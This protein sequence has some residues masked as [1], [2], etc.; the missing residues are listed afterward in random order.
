MTN[1]RKIALLS[2]SLF[3]LTSCSTLVTPV[4]RETLSSCYIVFDAGSSGTR[5][6]VYEKQGT[7]WL[8][9]AGPKVTALADPIRE[10]RG[11]KNTDIE[12]VTTEVVAALDNMTQDGPI[13]KKG[14]PAWIGF[15]W[16][17]QCQVV[18]SMV[19]ATAGMRL[20]EQEDREKSIALWTTLKQK[21]QAKV[22]DAVAV[23]TRT[24]TGYEEGLYAW[25]AVRTQ[26]QHNT[27]GIAEMGGA[28]SQVTFPCS[29]CDV[30]D[31]ALKLVLVNGSPLPIYSYSFLGLGQDEAPTTLGMPES[32]AYGIGTTQSDWNVNDCANQIPITDTQGIHDPYNFNGQKRGTY[33]QIPTSSADVTDWF[34]TGAFNYMDES[35][36]DACCLNKGPCFN[37]ATSCFRAVYLEEYLQS[38]N[39]PTNA[40]KM[41]VSWTLGAVMCAAENCLQNATAPICRWSDKGCL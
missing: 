30:A 21:L 39:I 5:L 23:T 29:Q 2:I 28:S 38:L 25:L 19:Y 37:E 15:N 12:A 33:R 24:L 9:H 34:L 3:L 10:I 1:H 8:E 18:A 20:A 41:D 27:F 6:Y 26:K 11:K 13:D 32:C 4:K 14:K 7:N 22:G 16:S 40:A 17:K 35:Q 36:I 31:D